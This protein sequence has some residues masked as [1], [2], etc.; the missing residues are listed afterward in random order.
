MNKWLQLLEQK[1]S[2]SAGSFRKSNIWTVLILVALFGI[3]MM[4]IHSF[5]SVTDVRSISELHMAHPTADSPT[6]QTKTSSG[7][8]NKFQEYEDLLQQ[9]LCVC[10]FPEPSEKVH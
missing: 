6:F 9:D 5:F 7:E 8:N 4:F 1:F 3:V 10:I 2:P